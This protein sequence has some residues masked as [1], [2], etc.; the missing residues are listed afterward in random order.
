MKLDS[1]LVAVGAC[2][3][4]LAGPQ[5]A[6]EPPPRVLEAH[7][8]HG[9]GASPFDS[10]IWHDEL[11]AALIVRSRSG[12]A[13]AD[14]ERVAGQRE[15]LPARL[16]ELEKAGFLHREGDRVRTAF[17]VLIGAE[18]TAY[19]ALVSNAAASIEQRMRGDWRALLEDLRA[20]G[21]TEWSYHFV[22]SQTMDSGFAW[23]PMMK[24]R[25]VPPLSELVVWVVSPD[26][27]FKSGT[28]YYP[29][30]ELRDQMLAVTWRSGAS[31]TV[32][33]IASEWR[34]V[35]E[36]ALGKAVTEEERERL[37]VMGLTDR[38][39]RVRIPVVRKTD[40]LYA[41]LEKLGERHVRLM[42]EHLPLARLTTLTGADEARTF[43]MAYHDASWDV[44]RR[45]AER[46][47]L[48]IPPS[49]QRQA[50]QDVSLAGVCA[51]IDAHPAFVSEL[52]KALGIAKPPLP[53][54]PA[55]R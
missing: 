12:A 44:L 40:P 24:Q 53:P 36:A 10:A 16:L 46:D 54:A 26:H 22:W 43:A 21:W 47:A 38:G 33:R 9:I 52:K 55:Q 23:A 49:L 34:V 6:G 51:V 31:N 39:G 2:L 14:L 25:L 8:S 18:R 27:P 32:G 15:D 41:R 17:P 5:T 45:M 48:A 30:T 29:D 13:I 37:R 4:V 28:N 35:W 20:R 1:A 11:N 19:G 7:L 42:T 50:G 3:A